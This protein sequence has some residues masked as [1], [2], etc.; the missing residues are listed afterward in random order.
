MSLA[1]GTKLG[2]YEI[3]AP[4]GTGGMGEVYRARD[5][6]LGR[7]VA[8]KVLPEHLSS[9]PEIR[10]RFEREAKT[11]SSLN[12]AHICTLHDIG[13]EGDT[14]YLVMELVEGETLAQRL[15]KGALP[16]PE[17][18]RIGTQITDAL[19]RAHRAGVV[20]RDLKPGNVMLTKS[21]VKLLDFGLAR[22]TGLGP[23]DDMTSSPT[24]AA[25]LT[26]EGTILGTFQYMAP[27]QLEGA[28]ADARADLW[29]LGC[30]LYEMATGRRT[31]EGK[32]QA[33]LIGAIMNATPLPI[34]QLAPMT[35]PA[36]DHLIRMCLAKDPDE[37]VQ[38]AHDIRLQ[39]QWIAEGGS[40]TGA[41]AVAVT[42]RPA[43]R[44]GAWAG[45]AVGA[46]GLAMALVS[47]MRTTGG[48]PDER[49]TRT[50][51]PAPANALFLFTGD[52]GGPPVLSPDGTRLAFVAV[53]DKGG[54]QLWVRELSSLTTEAVAGTGNACY[55]FWS[56]DG[57]SVGFFADGKLKRVD[58]ST[59]QVIGICAAP[60]GRGGTWSAS[61][62][63]VFSPDFQA[64]LAQV[65]AMG[66]SPTPVTTRAAGQTTHRWP[67]FLPDGK[68]VL[69]YSGNH[70]NI[71]GQENSI[72]VASLDGRENRM[73]VPCTTEAQYADGYLFYVQD[74]V[75]VARPFDARS[76]QFTGEAQPTADRVQFDP[77][78][79]K[80]NFSVSNADVLIY[81]TT[82]GKQ[83]SEIRLYDRGG[84]MIRKVAEGGN[85]FNV[86]ISRDGRFVA[87]SS[88][89]NPNGD[90]F[91]YDVE[92]SLGRR[93]TTGEEDED[94]PVFSPDDRSIAFTKRLKSGAELGLYSIELMDAG[95]GGSRTLAKAAKDLWPLD[96]SADGRTM[97]VGS[98]VFSTQVADTLGIVPA[99]G[100]GPVRPIETE[101][102]AVY[103]GRISNGGRWL[104]YGVT[105]GGESNVY[106][107]G[108]PG[109][110]T[111]PGGGTG[112]AIQVSPHG[113]MLPVWG[114]GDRELVYVRGDGMVVSVPLAPGTMEPGPE[115]DLF[116]VTLRPGTSALDMSADGQR[117]AVDT[118]ASEGAAPIVVVTNW[119][120]ELGTR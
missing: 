101:K 12:H 117:F 120:H 64:A 44:W 65:P 82:G 7:D 15:T 103:W 52:N 3:V 84:T 107:A 49:V 94:L 104:A 8:I 90:I 56:A 32:S 58:L 108:V 73:I 61:D 97:L 39:L 74:S 53:D 9:Q 22:A 55:P 21:G 6:R 38:T 4:I 66:G 114:P 100:A 40:Q 93:L 60:A 34:S 92:R 68:R 11:I 47:F 79:W 57:R 26:A 5:S 63:I 59:H 72:W 77:T 89:I 31:F 111:A 71:G 18:L 113:G 83:G 81:Q 36:L 35:P 10:A 25:P 28:E 95:G 110:S 80:A 14:D 46:V 67:Q 69:Y 50:I 54:A 2:P 51:V 37:R 23:A 13:R 118:L 85:H 116:R 45:W 98:G 78:T 109:A 96:W 106:I 48:R 99:N 112:R 20:H 17:V 19:D 41:P 24:V 16:L 33:S 91:S 115:R 76:A 29:A 43:Q 87:Y 42:R 105:S 119:K 1:A 70:L 30:V 75:L 102:G 27:E 62:V 86:R 88:Q